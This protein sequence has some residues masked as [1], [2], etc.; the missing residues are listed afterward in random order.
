MDKKQIEAITK[1]VYGETFGRYSKEEFLEFLNPLVVRLSSNQISEQVFKGKRCLDA[2]CGGGRASIMMARAGASEVVSFDL[3]EQNIE[4]T[5]RMAKLFDLKNVTTHCG[6]LLEI[7]FDDES[8]DI[9][10][11]NGVLHHTVDCDRGISEILRVLKTGGNFW[12]YLYGSGGIYW[13][14]MDFLREWVKEI[15]IQES[16]TYMAINEVPT[17]RIAEFIDDWYV[18]MLQ[19]YTRADI[20]TR[21]TELG[22]GEVR[23]LKGGMTYDTSERRGSAQENIWMGDGDL[24]YWGK[25]TGQAKGNSKRLPSIDNKGSAYTDA[26]EV[27]QF[28]EDFAQ[29]QKAVTKFETAFPTLGK[30]IRISI[31]AQL[32]TWLRD[33]MTVPKPFD[34]A[35]MHSVIQSKI[36]TVEKFLNA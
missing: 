17:G 32:Q 27:T 29:L 31:S 24:R 11:C 20:E 7:P 14:L 25:K 9:V 10:W 19:R 13:Y 22:V 6:S 21:L 28:S 36:E 1:I 5:K 18:P 4:T 8:F 30:G 34:G 35:E 33:R 26:K 2:G 3:S 23:Y 16:I 15:G 12:L